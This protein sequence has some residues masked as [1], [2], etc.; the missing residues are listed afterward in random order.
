ML[1]FNIIFY[2]KLLGSVAALAAAARISGVMIRKLAGENSPAN[3]VVSKFVR[4]E[5]SRWTEQRLSLREEDPADDVCEQSDS[6]EE[7]EQQ[8]DDAYDCS[9]DSQ[10]LSNAAAYAGDLLV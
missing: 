7:D 5:C 3:S 10:I 9:V 4:F 6:A 2:K 1:K 8:P